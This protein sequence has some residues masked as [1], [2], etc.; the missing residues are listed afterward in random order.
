M[1]HLAFRNAATFTYDG[2]FEGFLTLVFRAFRDKIRPEA[3][4]PERP[5]VQIPLGDLVSI[6]QKEQEA[7]RVWQGLVSR[8]SLKNAR[9]L[10][11][12]FLAEE[13]ATEMLLWNYLE[14][15]FS[16]SQPDFF[17]NM[18]D[19]TVF[20]L[21]QMA[22]RVKLEVHR[23]HGFVRFQKTA[24]GMLFAPVDPDHN[25]LRLMAH[26][27]RKRFS[28]QHWVIYDTRRN[29]GIYYDTVR[30]R[31]IVLENHRIDFRS[32]NVA[33]E[34]RDM[35]EDFYCRL[36]QGYYDAVNILERKNHRQMARSMPRRYW[37]YLPEKNPRKQV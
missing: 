18:L 19:D 34:V 6:R 33:S 23:F 15:V 35:D 29:F 5:G 31:E 4:L 13:P 20:D 27:F 9:L 26:H 28:G 2:S 12:A 32:G 10:H 8:T 36:W 30:V 16:S 24:D 25:I 7:Q 17:L 11:V 37:K 21:V 14:K 22:R 1:N 3:I